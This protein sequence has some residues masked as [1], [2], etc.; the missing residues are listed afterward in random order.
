MPSGTAPIFAGITATTPPVL[1]PGSRFTNRAYGMDDGT[2][3]FLVHPNASKSLWPQ[4]GNADGSA[5]PNMYVVDVT[6]SNDAS[7]LIL[8]TV[9][10]K[11][12]AG[13]KPDRVIPDCDISMMTIP[14]LTDGTG[15]STVVPVPQPRASREYVYVLAAGG[16]A[17]TLTGVGSPI[18]A[19]W[20]PAAPDWSLTYVPD[21]SKPATRNYYPDKWV[22]QNRTPEPIVPGLVWFIRETAV[23]YYSLVPS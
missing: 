12:I 15:G 4:K 14:T 2:R 11:G 9:S 3:T 13:T 7:S 10:Y 22:L 17:P 1:Q 5:N 16:T 19:D 8:L 6:P 20:L 21:T 18:T 23:Y